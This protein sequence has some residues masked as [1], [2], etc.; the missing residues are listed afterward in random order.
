MSVIVTI[1][2]KNNQIIVA[3]SDVDAVT[4]IEQPVSQTQ[5]WADIDEEAE[6]FNLSKF[7]LDVDDTD[8]MVLNLVDAHGNSFSTE[9][10]G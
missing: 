6:I 1:D 7:V 8:G 9:V 2:F 5:L 10:I 3:N 4:Q